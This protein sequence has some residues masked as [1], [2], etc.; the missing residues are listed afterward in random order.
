MKICMIG[1]GAMV[2]VYGG[3]LC[4]AGY[5]VTLV[6]LRTDHVAAIRASGLRVDGMGGEHVVH[7]P[8]FEHH[9]GLGPFDVAIVFVD[10]NSAH[11]AAQT[12][13]GNCISPRLIANISK[14]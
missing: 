9:A 8:V 4:A 13:S 11:A 10:G 5:D 3:S 1:S 14:R 12:A 7:P 2:S 6:D